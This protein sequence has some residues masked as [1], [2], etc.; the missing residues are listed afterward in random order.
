MLRWS[1]DGRSNFTAST[2]NQ[3]SDRA[4]PGFCSVSERFRF[5]DEASDGL[6]GE[7]PASGR[8]A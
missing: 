4:T 5:L 6:G 1:E 8:S 7:G 3:V 2:S